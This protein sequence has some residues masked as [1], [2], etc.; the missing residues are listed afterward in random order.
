MVGMVVGMVRVGAM[1]EAVMDVVVPAAVVQAVRV[2]VVVVV[3]SVQ[4][5]VRPTPPPNCST[6]SLVLQHPSS[7]LAGSSS[8]HHHPRK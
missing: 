8:A 2:V 4:V 6:R 3:V 7:R 5:Q 1:A